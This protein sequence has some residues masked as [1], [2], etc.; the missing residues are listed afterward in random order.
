VEVDDIEEDEAK[1]V[2]DDD[3][4]NDDVE[5]EEEEEE[6]NDVVE[7]DDVEGPILCASLHNRNAHER[8]TSHEN[9]FMWNF[10]DQEGAKLARQTFCEPAH[11]K[12]DKN[13]GPQT[14]SKPN[15]RFSASLQSQNAPGHTGED[16]FGS[17]NSIYLSNSKNGHQTN[18]TVQ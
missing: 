2:E 10:T 14:K 17:P 3:V 6:D 1:G 5:E 7:D 12:C 11:S 18:R 13:K 16:V 8:V 15:A 9:T 4:K